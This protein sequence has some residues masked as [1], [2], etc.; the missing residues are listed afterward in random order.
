MILQGQECAYHVAVVAADIKENPSGIVI[1][2]CMI[3]KAECGGSYID[4]VFSCL[5]VI[6]AA[7]AQKPQERI[8]GA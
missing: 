5:A 1:E 7:E 2:R 8:N 6:D 4:D 3:D